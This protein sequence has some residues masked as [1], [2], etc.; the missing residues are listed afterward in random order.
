MLARAGRRAT[1]LEADGTVGG[2]SKTVEFGDFRF[3]LGGH[4]FYTKLVPVQRLW[5][6]MLGEELLTRP[7]MSRIYYR[8]RFFSYPLR[9]QDVFQG[10]G[11]VESGLAAVSYVYWRWKLR[12][13]QPKT[14]EDWVVGRF[15]R[16]LYGPSSG[17][18]PRRSGAFRA[19]RSRPSG[20]RSA[21]RSSASC[22]RSSASWACSEASRAR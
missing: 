9:A 21:S 22:T 3:D 8:D 10:L 19:R 4:R 18:T 11:L 7:R 13:T 2:I 20:L 14:F 1:V 12:N 15:G 17:P 6:E 16:R 5:E